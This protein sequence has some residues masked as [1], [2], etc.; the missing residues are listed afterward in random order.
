MVTPRKTS[1]KPK[2]EEEDGG[3]FHGISCVMGLT[4]RHQGKQQPVGPLCSASDLN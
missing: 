3:V 1:I 2:E 4:R